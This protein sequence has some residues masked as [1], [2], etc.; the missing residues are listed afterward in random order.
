MKVDVWP[1]L[2]D[3]DRPGS[4]L[5]KVKES[6]FK[7]KDMLLAKTLR[8]QA[9][10]LDNITTLGDQAMRFVLSN[11]GIMKKGMVDGKISKTGTYYSGIG[12][13]H[14]GMAMVEI[15]NCLA[16]IRSLP[17]FTCVL[18]HDD[19]DVISDVPTKIIHVIGKKLAPIVP[20]YFDEVWY[21][22][23]AQAAGGV[24]NAVIQS[25]QHPTYLTRSRG[26]LSN[27]T[28]QSLG[29][30]EILKKIGYEFPVLT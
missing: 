2:E 9:V 24:Y 25:S 26:S 17:L 10:C 1:C 29:M 16:G 13:E 18:A 21:T 30:I 23:I 12:I 22:M 20:S 27:G 15:E 14:Y 6:I 28:S 11:S 4:G 7:I 3:F 8:A 5:T 19:V